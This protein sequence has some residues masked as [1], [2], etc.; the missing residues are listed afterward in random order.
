M[1]T[2]NF[3]EIAGRKSKKNTKH[4]ISEYKPKFTL[5]KNK[6]DLELDY[7]FSEYETLAKVHF[8]EMDYVMFMVQSEIDRLRIKVEKCKIVAWKGC[9]EETVTELV[10]NVGKLCAELLEEFSIVQ[11]EIELVIGNLKH[12]VISEKIYLKFGR[13]LEEF[14]AC[15]DD[16]KIYWL[17]NKGCQLFKNVIISCEPYLIRCQ[18]KTSHQT[19]SIHYVTSFLILM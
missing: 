11:T 19:P 3:H 12:C 13:V 7:C 9:V 14:A 2:R 5:E 8:Y 4:C 18:N 1:V 6:N 10:N 17:L 16:V 15:I